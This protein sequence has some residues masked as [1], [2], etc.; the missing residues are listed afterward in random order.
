MKKGLH[1]IDVLKQAARD[2]WR[3]GNTRY[4]I[5][6]YYGFVTKEVVSNNV[7]SYYEVTAEGLKTNIVFSVKINWPGGI[8]EIIRKPKNIT[9]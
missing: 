1:I 7:T 3:D 5:P 4:V 9:I 2:V 6:T 8:K